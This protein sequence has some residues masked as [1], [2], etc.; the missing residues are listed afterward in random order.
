MKMAKKFVK[1]ENGQ[2]LY[3]GIKLE[4]F[5]PDDFFK[6]G[7]AEQVGQSFLI[8]GGIKA[9]HYINKD[10]DRIKAIKST[11]FY[12]A[13]FYT[14]PDEISQ[15]KIDIG[16]G[17]QKYIILTYYK[18]GVLFTNSEIIRSAD[19]MS[20]LVTMLT[21]GKLDIVEY[22]KIP[23]M[24]QLCKYYNNINFGVPAMY[25]EVIVADY[26]RDPDNVNRPARFYAN[27][28]NIK[29][30]FSLGIGQREKASFTSTFSGITFE[31]ITSMV[32]MADNAKREGREEVISD[33]EKVSL[34][35]I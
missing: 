23:R 21:A 25:E 4:L 15:D 22:D 2:I 29:N 16:Q 10:D 18:N 34:G 33:V 7:L 14:M 1:E 31:D 24:I 11:L 20:A 17:E 5:V 12:P 19:N 28:K 6:S 35:L 30:F 8:F 32:T 9:Y 13:K 27:D 3:D 26:Y